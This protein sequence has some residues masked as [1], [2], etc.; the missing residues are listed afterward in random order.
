MKSGRGERE[1]EEGKWK[2]ARKKQGEQ[3]TERKNRTRENIDE[4]T[5]LRP[6]GSRGSEQPG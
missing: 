4:N 6:K 1:K 2:K 5:T 3:E